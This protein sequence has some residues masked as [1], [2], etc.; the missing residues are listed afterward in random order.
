MTSK[1]VALI[2]GCSTGIGF[3]AAL[4]LARRG[5]MVF[6]TMRDLTKAAPLQK[7]ARGLPVYFLALDVDR[8]ASVRK[9]VAAVRKQAGRIDILI[10]NAG[11]GAFGAFEDFTDSEIL[12]QYQTNV[13]GLAR[14]T[15]EVLPLMRAQKSG[16]ILHI[17][18]LAGKM[19]FA[20]IGLYCSSKHAVEALTESLRMEVRPFGIQVAVVE[21]GS[22]NTAF[23]ANRRK[24]Q[25]FLKGKSPYQG[26]LEKIL[27]FGN[28]QSARAP[29]AEKVVDVVEKALNDQVMKIRYPVGKD[30]L[31]YPVIR[32]FL[33]DGLWDLLMRQVAHKFQT[34]PSLS[35]PPLPSSAP[36][37]LVT[38]ATSGFGL[39]T[40]RLLAREGFQVYATYRDPRK[41]DALRA[42][43]QKEKNIQPLFMDVTRPQ[44]VV[45]GISRLLKKEKRVDLLVN[46]AGFVMA[47]FLEDLSDEELQSQ[48]ETNV[49]GLL[50]VTRAVL[51][52]MRKKTKKRED[53]QCRQHLGAGG[54]SRN[55]RL[56]RLQIRRT[57]HHRGFKAGG[58]ALRH[59]GRRDRARVLPDESGSVHVVWGKSKIENV[60]LHSLHPSDGRLGEERIL[61]GGTAQP[62]GDLNS[63]GS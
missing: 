44:T 25:A 48:F 11:F 37:A 38:G 54:F 28:N 1:S 8:P 29:G 52:A 43:I 21:P 63:S 14:V 2:T 51:P 62:S 34:A 3:E 60:S 33:P 27:Q 50:R 26:S 39:E 35:A 55:R 46:N 58:P 4:R 42:L 16:R 30:A 41:L 61:K 23:K 5:T 40:A 24:N 18:S 19:T 15:K 45:Q 47:G 32:W 59:R 22:M 12:S 10:N 36:V 7:A 13:L 57:V 49:F 6:A 56:R 31:L 9:A 20:G 53:H 17:G